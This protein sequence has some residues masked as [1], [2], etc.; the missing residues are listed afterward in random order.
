MSW[1]SRTPSMETS[2]FNRDAAW[3]GRHRER[4]RIGQSHFMYRRDASGVPD[5]TGRR[6]VLRRLKGEDAEQEAIEEV[7]APDRIAYYAFSIY[8]DFHGRDS[9]RRDRISSA[10]VNGSHDASKNDGLVF[11]VNCHVLD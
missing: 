4:T 8:A 6:P 5:G 7:G 9:F 1:F 11:R 10:N 3:A 2:S